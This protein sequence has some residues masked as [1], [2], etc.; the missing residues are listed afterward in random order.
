MLRSIQKISCVLFL[1][2][3]LHHA[4]AFTMY[5][6]LDNWQLP[7][8]GFTFGEAGGSKLQG[9]EFRLN[10]PVITY[11]FD[12]SFLNYFGERGIKAVDEAFTILNRI[13]PTSRMTTNLTEFLTD[14]AQRTIPS[15][16]A[17]NLRDLKSTTLGL[18]IEHMGLAGEE[19]VF[20]LRKRISTPGTCQ[21]IYQVQLRNLDPI[22][23]VLIPGFTRYVNGTLYGYDIVDDCPAR[24]VAFAVERIID[25]TDIPFNAVA[26][27]KGGLT[28]P[29]QRLGGYYIGITRDDAGGLR[30]MYRRQNQNVGEFLPPD[31]QAQQISGPWQPVGFPSTNNV[32]TNTAAVRAGLQKISFRKMRFSP[33]FGS[34]FKP[35]VQ[36]YK[37]PVVTNDFRGKEKII[38]QAVRR[39]VVRPDIL[40]TAADLNNLPPANPSLSPSIAAR[41][42]SFVT[43]DTPIFS[44]P[45]SVGPGTILPQ[46]LITFHKATPH[47]FNQTDFFLDE[48]TAEPGFLWASFDG[49]TNE[50]FVYGLTANGLTLRDIER[51]AL[52]PTPR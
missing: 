29:G 28:S 32:S 13:P 25:P 2:A 42:I 31:A 46:T 45:E 5:G 14:D 12:Q 17:L 43:N 26:S 24:S 22:P 30:Y 21:F 3:G 7:E 47:F 48:I 37:S 8:V 40:F 9:E 16:E 23:N 11:G 15:A 6:A 36:S 49:T 51:R 33:I 50:P 52:N 35:F 38:N 10:T 44:A 27:F 39:L 1:A 41:S 20:D 34:Y 18:L 4:N 19:H